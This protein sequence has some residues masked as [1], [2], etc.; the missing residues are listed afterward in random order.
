MALAAWPSKVAFVSDLA[1]VA[2][3]WCMAMPRS[4]PRPLSF[5]VKLLFTSLC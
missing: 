3:E 4:E 1:L 5:V 2:K